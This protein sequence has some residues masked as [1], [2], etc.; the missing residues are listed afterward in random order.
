[1]LAAFYLLSLGLIAAAGWTAGAGFIFVLGL[2]AF[3]AHL[4]WQIVRLEIDDPGVCLAVFKSNRDA[5]L[6]LFAALALQAAISA[7]APV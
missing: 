5:G 3:A 2:L 1:M 6:L 4:A 7:R